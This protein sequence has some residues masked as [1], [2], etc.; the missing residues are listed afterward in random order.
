MSYR[1]VDSF[2]TGSWSCSKAVSLSSPEPVAQPPA[3]GPAHHICNP[4][5]R[6]AHLY[7][8]GTGFPLS[9]V[10][11]CMCCRGAVLSLSHHIGK[12]G[13]HHYT[14][15]YWRWYSHY[16]ICAHCTAFYIHSLFSCQSKTATKH[17]LLHQEVEL[18][19][20]WTELSTTVSFI[21]KAFCCSLPVWYKHYFLIKMCKYKWN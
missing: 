19:F 2:R 15:L 12:I 20:T 7:P 17:N 11:T 10:T 1:F 9:P 18:H 14:V 3:R 21:W 5:G 6:V 13:F 16:T 4:R 8:P